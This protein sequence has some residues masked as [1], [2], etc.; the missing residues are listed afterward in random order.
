MLRSSFRRSSTIGSSQSSLAGRRSSINQRDLEKIQQAL[1]KSKRDSSPRWLLAAMFT[2]PLFIF[3]YN[4]VVFFCNGSL[5]TA[6][7]A[8]E[9]EDFVANG[10]PNF[11][12]PVG[13]LATGSIVFLQLVFA[14]I[15]PAD[16]VKVLS[17]DG[18]KIKKRI[19]GF[20]SCLLICLL[21]VLGTGMGLY[22]GSVFFDNWHH[23][24]GVITICSLAVVL[25]VWAKTSSDSFEFISDFY[26]GFDVSEF[27]VD[28]RHLVLTR[29]VMTLW[30]IYVISA[31]YEHRDMNGSFSDPMIACCV[32]Q[33]LYIT[34]HMWYEHLAF[35]PGDAGTDKAGFYRFWMTTVFMVTVYVTPVSILA[36]SSKGA[37]KSSCVL[38]SAANLVFQYLRIDVDVQKYEFRVADGNVKIWDK[39]PFFINAKC[40]NEAGEGTVKLLLGSGYWGITRHMNYAMELLTFTT[41]ALLPK[42]FCV[43]P[44]FPLVFMAVFLFL[45]MTRVENEC[46]AKYGHYWIQYCSKVPFRLVPGLY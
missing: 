4:Y 6:L 44:H 42:S 37:S 30:P 25:L 8:N 3:Y 27:N 41:W 45:R 39:D 21:Y 2:S 17:A 23:V 11:L 15:L 29:L 32:L 13:W 40:R 16:E 33:L 20:S 28:L 38:L 22:R 5:F 24:M 12:N 43:L 35:R 34:K 26:Y 14:H 18:Q 31:L 1:L 7:V 10:L 19:N 36:H 46:L 9:P